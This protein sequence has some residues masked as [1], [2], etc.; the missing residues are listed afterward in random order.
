MECL[1]KQKAVGFD[2]IKAEFVTDSS[3]VL[4]AS[5]KRIFDK[6]LSSGDFPAIWKLDRKIPLFKGGDRSSP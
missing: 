2:E 5:I 3:D 4:V 6:I 1:K